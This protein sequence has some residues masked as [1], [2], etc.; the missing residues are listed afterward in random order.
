MD[1]VEPNFGTNHTYLPGP[2]YIVCSKWAFCSTALDFGDR[3]VPWHRKI[4]VR[5]ELWHPHSRV[6]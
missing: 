1:V 2:S 5:D 3:N 4:P 6:S